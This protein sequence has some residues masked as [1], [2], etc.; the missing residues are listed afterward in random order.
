MKKAFTS[1]YNLKGSFAIRIPSD[2]CSD[3]LFPAILFEKP[4]VMEIN[5]VDDEPCLIVRNLREGEEMI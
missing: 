5:T 4:I 3:S 2:I 1:L